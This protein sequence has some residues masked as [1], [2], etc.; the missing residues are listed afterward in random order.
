VNKSERQTFRAVASAEAAR[1]RCD[2]NYWL[3]KGKKSWSSVQIF[4]K[5]LQTIGKRVSGILAI[6]DVSHFNS[7][8]IVTTDENKIRFT[9]RLL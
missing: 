2:Q 7:I 3:K 8:H 4:D 1:R 9:I 5:P 6:S